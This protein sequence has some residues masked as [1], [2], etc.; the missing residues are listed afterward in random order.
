MATAVVRM[1]YCELTSASSSK[2]RKRFS[3]LLVTCLILAFSVY[4]NFDDVNESVLNLWGNMYMY[5]VLT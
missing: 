5:F 4:I 1:L 3:F 2:Y